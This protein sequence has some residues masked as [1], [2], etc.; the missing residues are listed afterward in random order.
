MVAGDTAVVGPGTYDERILVTASGL[1]GAPITYRAAGGVACRGFT[2][3]ADQI[4]IKGFTVTATEPSWQAPAHGI[5]VE[6]KNCVI[7]D[8]YAYYSPRGGIHLRPSSSRCIVRNNRSFRN[9]MVGIEVHGSNH[10]I[11]SNEVWGTIVYHT[12]TGLNN[13]DADGMRFFGN[14]HVFRGNYIHD[15]TFDDPENAGYQPHIDGFQTWKDSTHARATNVLFERNLIILPVYKGMVEAPHGSGFTL[16]NCRYIIVR[17]NIV[18]THAGIQTYGS[19]TAG[20]G[21][22]HHIRIENNTF[23]GRLDFLRANFPLGIGLHKCAY[24]T[25]KNNLIVNQV[26]HAVYVDKASR[27]GLSCSHSCC[28]NTDGSL[29]FGPRYRRDIWGIDPLFVDGPKGDYHLRPASPCIDAGAALA[30]LVNDFNGTPRPVGP[31]FDIGAFEFQGSPD[32]D[33]NPKIRPSGR[34]Q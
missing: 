14:G 17:N 13:D 34:T 23:I 22:S 7:E 25:V 27:T 30:G 19:Q 11:E 4:V 28:F 10:L 33:L 8:N 32:S 16:H 1:L 31:G 3:R 18:F 9:G 20:A 2:V 12:P 26:L 15:I 29:P 21:L 24:S 5:Y 6:G